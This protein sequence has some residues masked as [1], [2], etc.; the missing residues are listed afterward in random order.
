MAWYSFLSNIFTGSKAGG[1]IVSG[2]IKGIDALIFTEEEKAKF[3]QEVMK[4]WLDVQKVTANESSIRSVT[5]RILAVGFIISY[6]FLILAGCAVYKW[7]PVYSQ[8]L[9]DTAMSL[10][11]PVLTIIIFYFGY[12]AVSNI[13]KAKKE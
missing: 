6:L 8:F 9:F 1:G 11:T 2:A 4:V 12:Y 10:N 13:I 3:S 5:R 7:D